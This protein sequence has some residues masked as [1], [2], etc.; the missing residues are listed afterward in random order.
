[1]HQTSHSANKYISV[2]AGAV[3]VRVQC[4]VVSFEV[5]SCACVDRHR[6]RGSRGLSRGSLG[7]VAGHLIRRS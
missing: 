6:A 1:M 5:I 3:A 4:T 2:V 7:L